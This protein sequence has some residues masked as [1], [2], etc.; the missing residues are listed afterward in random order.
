MLSFPLRLGTKQEHLFSQ[1]LF[2]TVLYCKYNNARERKKSLEMK[3]KTSFKSDRIVYTEHPE[4]STTKT[5]SELS[6]LQ[7]ILSTYKI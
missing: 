5:I 6:I 7:D 4:E 1:L 2:N 3:N